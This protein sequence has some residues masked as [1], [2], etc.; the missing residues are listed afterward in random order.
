MLEI[1]GGEYPSC[2]GVSRRGFLKA[3][4]LGLT[5]LTLADTLRIRAAR[6]SEALPLHAYP[7]M[8]ASA[9]AG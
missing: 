2:D 6:A 5:G 7:C 1:T 9:S 4:V 8:I 3:G